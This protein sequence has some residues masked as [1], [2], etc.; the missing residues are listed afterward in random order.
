MIWKMTVFVSP[1]VV[2]SFSIIPRLLMSVSY[3]G[4]LWN[5]AAIRILVG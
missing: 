4:V 3:Y 1:G 2:V 5:A